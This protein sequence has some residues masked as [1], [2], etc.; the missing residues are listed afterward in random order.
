MHAFADARHVLAVQRAQRAVLARIPRPPI[1]RWRMAYALFWS[2]TLTLALPGAVVMTS[3]T[4]ARS[5]GDSWLRK[6]AFFAC[7]AMLLSSGH[8]FQSVA[9]S[10]SPRDVLFHPSKA[11]VLLARLVHAWWLLGLIGAAWSLACFLH[12]SQ[13][14]GAPAIAIATC[15]AF[16]FLAPLAWNVGTLL[17]R[18]VAPGAD[19]TLSILVVLAICACG[20]WALFSSGAAGPRW[21]ALAA[22]G[23]IGAAVLAKLVARWWRDP[24][25]QLRA[26]WPD[27]VR[28]PRLFVMFV[29]IAPASWLGEHLAMLAAIAMPWLVVF[30]ALG[31][32]HLLAVVNGV[33]AETRGAAIERAD[34]HDRPPETAR[35][36]GVAVP[37]HRGRSPSRATWR[38]HWFRH[39][40]A[41]RDLLRPKALLPF[42]LQHVGGIGFSAVLVWL[43]EVTVLWVALIVFGVSRSTGPV[44]RER[45]YHLGFDLC[46]QARQQ[47]ITV[48]WLALP[49]LLAGAV[50]G[51]IAGWTEQRALVLAG[52]AAA[53]A[54][55]IG[56]RGLMTRPESDWPRAHFV[57][58]CALGLAAYFLPELRPL[59]WPIVGTWAALGLVGLVRRVVLWREVELLAD[60]V[61]ERERESRPA[62]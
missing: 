26:L 34:E 13:A 54:L 35:P 45:L 44:S 38:L 23:V 33:E 30:T 19:P 21:W 60:L 27:L 6:W 56:W 61:A 51:T 15:C 41:R 31:L 53:Y 8:K 2:L 11:G 59:W 22:V 48:L 40:I 9:L 52:I 17:R 57:L 49:T 7:L 25:V 5:G 1:S 50:V 18:I 10:F 28:L 20:A 12:V 39:G 46:G 3:W 24:Q 37:G 29:L 36:R 14:T 62:A 47:V 32:R 43:G 42:L 58:F 55:R 16:A 4:D